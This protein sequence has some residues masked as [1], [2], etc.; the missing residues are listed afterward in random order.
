MSFSYSDSDSPGSNDS[1]KTQWMKWPAGTALNMT[2][3]STTTDAPSAFLNVIVPYIGNET[4]GA[5]YACSIDARWAPGK[6]DA[7]AA[8]RGARVTDRI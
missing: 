6:H 2:D 1:V 8:L 5:F 3:G 4:F 7:S